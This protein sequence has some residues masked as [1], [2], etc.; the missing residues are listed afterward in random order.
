MNDPN[1]LNLVLWQD[2]GNIM[3]QTVDTWKVLIGIFI[4]KLRAKM[5]INGQILTFQ[6]PKIAILKFSKNPL[7][8]SRYYPDLATKP[9]F[10]LILNT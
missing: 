10:R 7:S 5:K 8:V 4:G 1:D 2:W 3:V 9:T 6:V